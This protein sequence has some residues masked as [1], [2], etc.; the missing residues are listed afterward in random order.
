[1]GSL[2]ETLYAAAREYGFSDVAVT[3]VEPFDEWRDVSR[4]A[5]I[6]LGLTHDP[7]ALMSTARALVVLVLPFVPFDTGALSPDVGRVSAYY[8][9]SQR[10]YTAASRVAEAALSGYETLAAPGLPYKAIAR[11]AG[12]GVDGRNT[13]L[14]HD[15]FGSAV[16]LQVILTSAPLDASHFLQVRDHAA[17]CGGCTLCVEAC[18]VGAIKGDGVLNMARCLRAAMFTGQRVSRELR[19]P[20]DLRLLGCDDC[21]VCCPHNNEKRAP[22]PEDLQRL[23]SLRSLLGDS[24]AAMSGRMESIALL[25]GRNTARAAR[26]RT[27]AALCAGNT[28][29]EKFIPLLRP[30]LKSDV[31]AT[32]AHAAW[33]LVRLGD[34]GSVAEA[35]PHEADP[36]VSRDMAESLEGA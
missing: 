27:Q 13:L 19:A 16:A 35:I 29:D 21:R 5:G 32:R 31:D 25:L 33:S 12:L 23:F 14:M 28:G 30:L 7:R 17:A 11:R 18:P 22:V 36:A 10:A 2:S 3:S 15:K 1:M 20:M 8:P 24:G 9:A 4:S 34:R 6:T 26:W